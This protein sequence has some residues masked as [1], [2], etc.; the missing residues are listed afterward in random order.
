MSSNNALRP[1]A[2]KSYTYQHPPTQQ[3]KPLALLLEAFQK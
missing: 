2:T 1:H 3:K